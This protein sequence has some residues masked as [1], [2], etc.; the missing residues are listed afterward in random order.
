MVDNEAKGIVHNAQSR[1]F[2]APLALTVFVWV[3]LLNAMDLLPVDLLPGIWKW[4]YGAAGHDPEHAYL[5]VVPTADLSVTMG[6]SVGVLILVLIYSIKIK[7]LGG[8]LHELCVAPFGNVKLTGNPLS[9]IGFLL[10]AIVNV[11]MQLV[12]FVSKTVSHGMRLFG[13]MYAGELIFLLIAMLGGAFALTLG[14]L[15]LA[16]LHIALGT[17]WAIFHILII[18]IQA[19]VFMMLTLVYIGQAHDSH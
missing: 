7:G 16:V 1:K 15:A 5:R 8:W 19:Y 14:G 17:G 12:E 11:A 3:M 6:L 13:N 10:L 9:W 2:V 18:T 4:V